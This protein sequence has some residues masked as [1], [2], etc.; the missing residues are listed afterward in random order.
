MILI[1]MPTPLRLNASVWLGRMEGTRNRD[2][3]LSQANEMLAPAILK[4][5]AKNHFALITRQVLLL[6]VVK[7]QKCNAQD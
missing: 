6:Q 3:S 5:Y 1:R 7:Q 4:M 2:L